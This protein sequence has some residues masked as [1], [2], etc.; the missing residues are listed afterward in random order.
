MSLFIYGYAE[1]HYAECHYAECPYAECHHVFGYFSQQKNCL[2]LQKS[3]PNG[4]ILPNQ[5][6]LKLVLSS[7]IYLDHDMIHVGVFLKNVFSIYI[8]S[9]NNDHQYNHYGEHHYAECHFLFTVMLNVIMMSVVM[10]NVTMFFTILSDKK[11][12]G[13]SKK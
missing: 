13:S 11:L 7:T 1:C 2:G 10:L 4:K 9:L 6:T 5:V 3:N 8:F 12:P